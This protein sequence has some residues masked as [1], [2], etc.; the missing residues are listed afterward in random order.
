[1]DRVERILQLAAGS[2]HVIEQLH[3][4]DS[5]GELPPE[6]VGTIQ[7]VELP[8]CLDAYALDDDRAERA[9]V[10]AQRDGD[11]GRSRRITGGRHDF[12][13]GAAHRRGGGC[14]W[15][16]GRDADAARDGFAV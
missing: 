7:E 6:L 3:V 15:I 14:G 5:A 11:D 1:R 2:H 8:T 9:P 16:L 4:F 10:T 13:A 12:G